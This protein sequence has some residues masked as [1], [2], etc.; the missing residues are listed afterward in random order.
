MS[1]IVIAACGA[2]VALCAWA[3][4]PAADAGTVTTGVQLVEVDGFDQPTYAE[5][6]P[7]F[8]DLLFVTEKEGTVQVLDHE[9]AQPEPFLDISGRV[10]SSGEQGLLSMA[11]PPNYDE[12]RR[13]YVYYTTNRHCSGGCDIE[14][15]EFKR[16]K[17][18]P[19]VANPSS[20]RQV[21]R[22]THRDAANHNG[23]EAAFGLD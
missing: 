19:L 18:D 16:S 1:R 6:A 4:A 7:G 5:D 3:L 11:F 8:P 2:V 21:I 22:I 9:V 14:V 10:A 15:D 13:F 17:A 12:S 20:R 23:G